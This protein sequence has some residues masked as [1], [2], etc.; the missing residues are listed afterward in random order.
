MECG[1]EKVGCVVSGWLPSNGLRISRR[2]RA[3]PECAKIAMI[4]R[5]KRSDCMRVLGGLL[6][7]RLPPFRFLLEDPICNRC[8]HALC[9]LEQD[10]VISFQH[11]IAT[12]CSHRCPIPLDHAAGYSFILL[13]LHQQ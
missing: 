12:A 1:S 4:S 5:A 13:A 3:A 9:L 10:K 11:K 6:L 2:K 7:P 8:L